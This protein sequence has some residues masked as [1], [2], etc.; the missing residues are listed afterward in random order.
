VAYWSSDLK[1]SEVAELE[2]KLD[3]LLAAQAPAGTALPGT[4]LGTIQ[5]SD[6]VLSLDAH[7]VWAIP[8]DLLSFAGAGVSAHIMNGDGVAIDGTF[9]E[10][11][12][13]TVTAGVNVHG[14]LEYPLNNW[15]R[16]YG[17]ARYEVLEDLRYPELRMGGQIMVGQSMPEEERNR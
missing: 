6:L 5:W 7:F 12:L 15:F 4:D 3:Q 14:G 10:D 1:G 16:L 17:A 2:E 8:F 11:L 9:V 13:D